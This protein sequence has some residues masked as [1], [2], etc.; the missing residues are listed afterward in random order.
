MWWSILTLLGKACSGCLFQLSSSSDGG[1]K[2]RMFCLWHEVTHIQISA[3]N[4]VLMAER[5]MVCPCA[6]CQAVV[7][8]WAVRTQQ[9]ITPSMLCPPALLVTSSSWFSLQNKWLIYSFTFIWGFFSFQKG[10]KLLECVV[11]NS[12][13]PPK[14]SDLTG[15]LGGRSSDCL[16]KMNG[17][18]CWYKNHVVGA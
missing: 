17:E 6:P 12:K 10:V 3:C 16:M 7:W 15:M 1:R 9:P 11:K 5:V 2:W 4:C 14:G 13:Q 18:N 8:F